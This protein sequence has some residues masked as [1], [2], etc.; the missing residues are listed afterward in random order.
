M[1]TEGSVRR[2]VVP[3]RFASLNLKLI[4]SFLAMGLLPAVAVGLYGY[5][6]SASQ[7]EEAA[8]ARLEDAAITDG[9]IID[10]NLFERYGDVQAFAANPLARGSFADRQG[11]V[12]FLTANSGKYDIMLIVDLDGRVQTANSVDGSGEPLDATALEGADVSDEEWFQVVVAGETPPGGTYYTDVHRSPLVEEVY[13]DQR[14]TLPFTAP[15]YDQRDRMVAVW[16]NEASFER[17]VADVM[18]QRRL[19]FADQGILSIETQVLRRDGLVIDD[20]DPAAVFDLNL[21]DVGL[22]AAVGATGEVGSSGFVVERHKRTGIEQINGFAV[23]DGALGFDGYDWGVLVRQ[24]SAEAAAPAEALRQSLWLI[25]AAVAVIILMAGLSLARS[26]S[27]PLRRNARTLRKVA[28]GDLGQRFEATTQ[29]EVGQMAVGFNSALDSITD[30][31]A[32]VTLSVSNLSDSSSHLNSVS[33]D[34]SEVAVNGAAQATQVAAGAEEIAASSSS[35]AISI[36][37]LNASIREITSSTNGAATLAEQAVEKSARTEQQMTKLCSSAADIGE[38]VST[39]TGIAE[40]TNL[41]ALNATIE[42]ARAGEAG[43]GFAVVANEVKDLATQTATATGE[44]QAKVE[45]IQV[46]TTDAVQAI[47]EIGE[48]IDEMRSAST[49]IAG[50]IEEQSV[51]TDNIGTEIKT[52][53]HGTTDISGRIAEMAIAADAT[54]EGSTQTLQA[55][56]HLADIADQL[57]TL[58][59]RFQ[60]P[61]HPS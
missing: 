61:D 29:D 26:L 51:T 27:G 14:L 2:W 60:L 31:L 50:A 28:D 44:I 23:A 37:Q 5:R 41:L 7:L 4:V 47:T 19:A 36:D 43:K 49:T 40:Q 42:A 3:A 30:T 17:V 55:A 9:D 39:I 8:A 20:A 6:L 34:M 35:V 32:Q 52:V 24:D 13:G 57:S 53:S 15:I 22:Q 10:R 18:E 59:A 48:L 11:I 54:T 46:D 12:D 25:S 58:L 38:V 16:H 33:A 56:G 45:T 21:L 1:G